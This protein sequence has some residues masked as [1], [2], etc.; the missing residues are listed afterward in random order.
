MIRFKPLPQIALTDLQP[1]FY[2]VESVSTVEMV[3]KLYAYLKHMYA[4]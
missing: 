3:G 1:C 2:D 4:I